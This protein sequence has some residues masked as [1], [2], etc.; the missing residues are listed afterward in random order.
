MTGIPPGR[1]TIAASLPAR[2]EPLQPVTVTI[3][4][5]RRCAELDIGARIDGR[6]SGQ[7]LDEQGQPLRRVYVHLADPTQARSAQT[8]R[9]IDVLTDD[10]GHFEFRDISPGRYVV[11][12]N[13]RTP[14]LHRRQFYSEDPDPAAA[15]V[16]ELRTAERRQLPPF[17]MSPLP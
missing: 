3:D 1:F 12:V 15:T 14:L 7:L 9:T 4:G 5:K 10:Q 2:F 8:P 17:R 11:D 6:I 13:L 16:V